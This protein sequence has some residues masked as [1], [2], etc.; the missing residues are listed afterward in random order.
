MVTI[1]ITSVVAGIHKTKVGSHPEIKLIVAN[2]DKVAHI[3]S[4]CMLVRIPPL[5]AIPPSLHRV[6]TYP[7]SGDP[8]IWIHVPRMN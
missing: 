4:D 1:I 6:I 2:D 8:V 7:R 5:E 3:D